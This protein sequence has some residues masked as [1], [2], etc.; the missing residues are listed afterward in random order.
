MVTMAMAVVVEHW[1]V[2]VADTDPPENMEG[3]VLSD[4][5]LST[6]DDLQYELKEF[7]S[8]A[9]VYFSQAGKGGFVGSWPL[10]DL[11]DAK[12]DYLSFLQL[13]Q[14]KPFWIGAMFLLI[15]KRKV[16]SRKILLIMIDLYFFQKK[17]S[18]VT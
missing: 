14:Y 12:V 8:A 3:I 16:K 15:T 7:L 11:C 10:V 2:A 4:V 9:I 13:A 17:E 1:Q 6:H 18:E 5:I